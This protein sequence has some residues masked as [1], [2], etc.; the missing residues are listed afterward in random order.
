RTGFLRAS[1]WMKRAL[2]V[3]TEIYHRRGIIIVISG[4]VQGTVTI[5]TRNRSHADKFGVTHQR[6]SLLR[7]AEL[8]KNFFMRLLFVRKR[9]RDKMERQLLYLSTTRQEQHVSAYIELNEKV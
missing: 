8:L 1:I 6:M 5:V 3:G 2:H 7:I 9:S 4:H